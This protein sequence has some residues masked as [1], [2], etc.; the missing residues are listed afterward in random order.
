MDPQADVVMAESTDLV[1]KIRVVTYIVS[2]ELA[3]VPRLSSFT[4]TFEVMLYS[5]SPGFFPASIKQSQDGLATIRPMGPVRATLKDLSAYHTDDYLQF[6]LDSKN[7]SKR[8]ISAEHITE[9]GLEEDCPIFVGLPDYAQLV[10]AAKSLIEGGA[11]I[12]IC[13]DGG[14]YIV[15]NIFEMPSMT[16]ALRHHSQK[17]Q[18]SGYCYVA[19][20]VLSILTLRRSHIALPGGS[21]RRPRIMYLDLD[22]HFSDAVSQSFYRSSGRLGGSQVL[23]LSVHHAAPGFFPPSTLSSLSD[24]LDPSFDP[25][26]L[27]LPLSQG[28][29]SSTFSKIWPSIEGV[30]DTFQ[31]DY[32]VVQCGVDGLVGDPCAVWN[33]SLGDREG[34]LGWCIDRICNHWRLKTL[35]LGGGGYNSPNAAR[36]WAYLTSIAVCYPSALEYFDI[37]SDYSQLERPLPLETDIPDHPAFPLYAP[38]F[39]LDVPAGYV[40]DRNSD[41]YLSEVEDKFRAI[42]EIIKSRIE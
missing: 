3:K 5:H 8:N 20:C 31:P 1:G 6:I 28:A 21:T 14:R 12:A 13:W 10:A 4:R 19:D 23:T 7:V 33:W 36:A 37:E 27:S 2:N 39:T 17:A 15:A 40:Q 9:F 25:F 18:A 30:K 35:L 38:S 29:C 26:T 41:A 11:D 34:S 24:P 32:V 22:L 16:S 42:I